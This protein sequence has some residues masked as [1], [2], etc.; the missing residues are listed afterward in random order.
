M[1]KCDKDLV[2][3]LCHEVDCL[4]TRDP[5]AADTEDL[6]RD[7]LKMNDLLMAEK[8][9]KAECVAQAIQLKHAGRQAEAY[10]VEQ[11]GW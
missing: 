1:K 3:E 9:V 10:L 7:R 5:G 6:E 2:R 4:V 8:W 11:S